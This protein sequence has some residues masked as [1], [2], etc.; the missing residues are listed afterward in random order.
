MIRWACVQNLQQD[1]H[2]VDDLLGRQCVSLDTLL[3]PGHQDAQYIAAP[4]GEGSALDQTHRELGHDLTNLATSLDGG[5]WEKKYRRTSADDEPCDE[6]AERHATVDMEVPGCTDLPGFCR[7][8]RLEI[9]T[10]GDTSDD[11]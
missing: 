11:V 5:Q 4:L 8:S 2:I 1:T 10:E 7:L 3:T 9:M 6:C